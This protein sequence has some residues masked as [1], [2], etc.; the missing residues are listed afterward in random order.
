MDSEGGGFVELGAGLEA[1]AGWGGVIRDFVEVCPEIGSVEN[2]RSDFGTNFNKIANHPATPGA[3]LQTSTQFHKSP[4][5][6]V[7]KQDALCP[8]ARETP[9]GSPRTDASS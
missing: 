9:P 7:H 5:L 1:C 8:F 3:R 4:A 6:T 2:Y